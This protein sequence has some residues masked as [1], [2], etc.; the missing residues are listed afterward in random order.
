MRNIFTAK[1]KRSIEKI[2]A[3][4]QLEKLTVTELMGAIPHVKAINTAS[5]EN[6]EA[7]GKEKFWLNPT[8]QTCFNYGQFSKQDFI[9]WARGTGPIVKGKNQKEKDKFMK[10]AKAA[11][12]L[13]Y[14]LFMYWEHLELL[15]EKYLRASNMMSYGDYDLIKSKDSE[16][17]IKK[18]LSSFVSTMVPEFEYREI[19]DIRRDWRETWYGTAYTLV[20][21][22]HGAFGAC[23]TP[24]RIINL[25]WAQDLVFAKAYYLHLKKIDY[26]FPDIDFV[27]KHRHDR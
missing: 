17:I 7:E 19:D 21:L 4:D 1:S 15:T 6:D 20:L 16:E 11:I 8:Q 23:N 14:T 2:V 27:H 12:E 25:S 24:E 9:D 18:V 22:G 13:N 10:Y 5:I 26:D 3:A